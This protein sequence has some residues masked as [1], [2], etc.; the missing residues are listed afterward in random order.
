MR[1]K[2]QRTLT[3]LALLAA[4]LLLLPGVTVAEKYKTHDRVSVGGKVTQ[5]TPIDLGIEHQGVKLEAITFEE[6]EATLIVWN[7]TTGKVNVN[8]GLALFDEGGLLIAAQSDDRPM[9]RS[10]FSI[11]SGKQA[12]LKFKFGKFLSY[13]PEESQFRL[14]VALVETEQA[15]GPG[16]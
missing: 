6:D 4:G 16:W 5:G 3:S 11:R 15:P 14:V 13:I 10:I 8:A 9:T 2:P 1:N 7:K 12:N